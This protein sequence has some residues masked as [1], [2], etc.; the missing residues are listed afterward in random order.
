[1]LD[2]IDSEWVRSAS[3]A[4]FW[5]ITCGIWAVTL[6]GFIGTFYFFQRLRLIE[7][8]P[9]SLVRSAAQGYVELQGSCKL[10]PGEPIIAPLTRQPCVWWSYRVEEHVGSG[11]NAHWQT[12]R[13][14]KSGELFLLE[15]ETGQCVVDPEHADVYPSAT[16]SWY[17]SSEMPEGGPLMGGYALGIGAR[18]RYVEQ[19]MQADDPLYA[20]GFFHTQGPESEG[21]I[22][23]EVRQLLAKWKQDQPWLKAHFDK[24]HDGQ[25]DEQEWDAARQEARRIVME[26]EREAMSRPPV[27]LLS[28]PRDDRPFILS[29][30]PQKKLETRLR[31]YVAACLLAFFAGGAFGTHAISLRLSPPSAGAVAA[32]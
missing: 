15:D 7:D 26:Q 31:L 18:Y 3:P 24:N 13:S 29:T 2:F 21:D 16:Q 8:T 28:K 19:R 4:N 23:E 6:A 17:G 30:L 12:V 1:M 32:P 22:N 10:M 25:I 14:E 9:K 20:L 5:L 11:K 27:N